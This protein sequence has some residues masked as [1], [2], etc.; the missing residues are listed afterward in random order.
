MLTGVQGD[1]KLAKSP[2]VW[3]KNRAAVLACNY[4]KV[5]NVA[6]KAAFF[7]H[8]FVKLVFMLNINWICHKTGLG[9]IV[10]LFSAKIWTKKCDLKTNTE[11]QWR[12]LQCKL[13]GSILIHSTCWSITSILVSHL[14]KKVF[15]M[16]YN[17]ENYNT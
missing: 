10:L 9:V 15:E 1:C 11:K 8:F 16:K 2:S 6:W 3:F 5:S 13:K 14:L 17:K 7:P 12:F 4:F